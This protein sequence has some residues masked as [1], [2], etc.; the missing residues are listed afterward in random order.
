MPETSPALAKR[1]AALDGMRGLAALAVALYHWGLATTPIVPAG[2]LAV[3]F[4]FVL[5]GFVIALTY[6]ERLAGT[7]SAREFMIMRVI[8]FYPIYLVG[9]VLGFLRSMA[10]LVAGNP[11][12]R[13]GT[14]LALATVFGTFMLP[15]PLDARNLFPLNVPSWTLFLE[16]LINVAF[17]L[18]MFQLSNRALAGIMAVS[19]VVLIGFTGPP[20]FMDVG[21]SAAT[22][23]LGIARVCY[24]FP[25]G[26][27]LFRMLGTQPRRSSW[28]SFIPLGVLVT[29]L[30]WTPGEA[31]RGAWELACVFGLFPALVA[32]GIRLELPA[33]LARPFEFLGA[34]SF[35][36]YAI[37]GPLI[38]FVNKLTEKLSLD[39]WAAVAVYLF[40]LMAAAQAVASL[41]DAPVR[42]MIGKWRRQRRVVAG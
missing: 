38:I 8:R 21:Y 16:L 41:F 4:F 3:D 5:S 7:L 40:I 31:Q 20:H 11:N 26:I 23:P 15:V 37:H 29:V 1:Y 30:A 13:G 35:A 32:A 2:Y 33:A 28:L 39:G 42:A 22:L 19:A 12:V 25:F 14:E 18:G 27:I 36:V 9:H 17:A 6:S 24:S 34:I 10:M